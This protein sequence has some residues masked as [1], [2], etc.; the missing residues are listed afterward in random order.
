MSGPTRT[1][2]AA[3]RWARVNDAIEARRED[4]RQSARARLIWNHARPI[5]EKERAALIRSMRMEETMTEA[6]RR[7]Q[8]R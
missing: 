1:M 6:R 8:R 2:L 4:E 7:G 3:Q 5:R